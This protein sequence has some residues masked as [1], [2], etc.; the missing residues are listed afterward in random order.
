MNSSTALVRVHEL[1]KT[2]GATRAVRSVSLSFTQGEIIGLVGENG[3]GKSTLAKMIAGVYTADSGAIEFAGSEVSFR[4]PFEALRAGVAMMAQEIMLVPDATVIENVFLG[5]TPRRGLLPNKAKMRSNFKELLELTKF[6]L[7]PDAVVSRLRLADQQK[8]EILRSLSR[9]AKLII[10]DEPSASLTADEVARLHATIRELSRRGVTILLI[11]H[12]L[13][14]VLELTSTTI[15]MRDGEVVKAGP[16]KDE[17]ID[18]LVSGMVG[19]SLETRYFDTDSAATQQVRFAVEGL[20]NS[21]L[22]DISF[23]IHQGEILGLAGLIGAGRTEIARAIFGADALE[24]GTVTLEGEK[25]SVTSPRDAIK[26]GIYMIPESR[27]EE[28]LILEASI[29]DNMMLSTL[30]R[31]R[32]G[33][34]LSAGKLDKRAVELAG[35][36]DL[37]YS[38]ITQSALSLSGG[39]Q[40]KILFGRAV[41]VAPKVLIVDEPTRGVDIA[42]KRAI[43]ETL[44]DLA[45]G[46]MSILFISSEIEEVLGVWDRV[47]VIHQGKVQAQFTAPFDQQQVVAAFFGQTSGVEHD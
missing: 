16:T 27:K 43:H 3:A 41:E 37:R 32:K 30:K 36:V 38:K 35:Q 9:N 46:G 17:T 45:K 15:V 7:N 29:S 21:A 33:G 47:L 26:Q 12:F 20:T 39:N 24:S 40:Q 42:A 1:T 22:H 34:S 25:L 6:E 8:V 13:E 18:S 5:S 31:Y 4:S 44:L 10:M 2:F 19:R 28:G 23:E 14:E 11:S